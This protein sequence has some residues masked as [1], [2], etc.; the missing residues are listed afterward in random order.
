MSDSTNATHDGN[1]LASRSTALT[2][3][4]F[5]SALSRFERAEHCVILCDTSGSMASPADTPGERRID[6]LRGVVSALRTQGLQ[7]RLSCFSS[8]VLWTDIIPEP[9]GG[10]DMI[11]ALNFVKAAKPSHLVIISDGV[12]DG[13]ELGRS[14]SLDTA[15]TLGCRIDAYYVGP[16]NPTAEEFMRSLA[17]ATGGSSGACSF[18][19][20]TG[21]IAGA[22]TAGEPDGAPSGPIAL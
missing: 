16:S 6:A 18:K 19:E 21:R 4:R 3:S 12:P 7:F 1:A 5:A 11:G 13:G 15:R 8:D 17:Q 22:L 20:L 10:T 9:S 2:R 14:A